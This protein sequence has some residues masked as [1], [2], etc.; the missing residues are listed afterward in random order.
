MCRLLTCADE[1][2][3]SLAVHDPVTLQCALLS[4]VRSVRLV[5]EAL[6]ADVIRGGAVSQR[7][8]TYAGSWRSLAGP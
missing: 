6:R 3:I 5:D 2:S 4:M 8:R 7:D 1:S